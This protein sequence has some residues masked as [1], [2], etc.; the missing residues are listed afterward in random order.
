MESAPLEEFDRQYRINVRAPFA[1]TQAL[2]PMLITRR[3]QIVFINSSAGINAMPDVGHYAATRHAIK[4][5][6]GSLRAE[7]TDIHIRPFIKPFSSGTE[8]AN[9]KGEPIG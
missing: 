7:V 3:G 1:L 5:V 2:L 8:Q 6:A 9:F 4:A